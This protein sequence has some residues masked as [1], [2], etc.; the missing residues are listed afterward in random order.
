MILLQAHYQR[1]VT[2][3]SPSLH[4]LSSQKKFRT[5]FMFPHISL[6]ILGFP[7]FPVFPEK[8]VTLFSHYST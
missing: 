4:K 8:V 1:C 5:F 6:T 3:N 7:T 2:T